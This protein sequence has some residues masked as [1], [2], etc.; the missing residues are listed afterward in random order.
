MSDSQNTAE[1]VEFDNKNTPRMT[2][3][4]PA[5]APAVQLLLPP[6]GM[7]KMVHKELNPDTISAATTASALLALNKMPTQHV[8][9]LPESQHFVLPQTPLQQEYQPAT[10]LSSQDYDQQILI[11]QTHHETHVAQQCFPC[12]KHCLMY[13]DG[14]TMITN[15]Q[16]GTKKKLNQDRSL[17]PGIRHGRWLKEEHEVFLVGLHQ[18]GKQWTKI[19]RI[20]R[21]RT[22]LQIRTHA[23]KYFKKLRKEMDLEKN[24]GDESKSVSAAQELAKILSIAA[25]NKGISARERELSEKAMNSSK[26]KS[27]DIFQD[28]KE[29]DI[30][31]NG[32]EEEERLLPEEM[33]GKRE[34]D[35]ASEQG[36]INKYDFVAE[37]MK[38]RIKVDLPKLDNSGNSGN[39]MDVLRN[40]SNSNS[41]L[42]T[43]TYPE[44]N[45]SEATQNGP[46]E[47]S[48]DIKKITADHDTFKEA[49]EKILSQLQQNVEN[50]ISMNNLKMGPNLKAELFARAQA[51][52]KEAYELA[53]A[54]KELDIIARNTH[55][56]SN[57]IENMQMGGA[58]DNKKELTLD[59][60]LPAQQAVQGLLHNV[61]GE[62]V[63]GAGVVISTAN[64]PTI[65]YPPTST[66]AAQASAFQTGI[67]NRFER[68]ASPTSAQLPVFS[69]TGAPPPDVSAPALAAG[70]PSA[71]ASA[72]PASATIA[73]SAAPAAPVF[74]TGAPSV[75][76][77]A[78]VFMTGAPSATSQAPAA[79]APAP[80]FGTITSPALASVPALATDA[81]KT[82][83]SAPEQTKNAPSAEAS[84][85]VLTTNAP[86]VPSGNI[87]QVVYVQAPQPQY[88]YIPDQNGQ[89]HQIQ[90]QPCAPTNLGTAS[91]NQ[92]IYTTNPAPAPSNLTYV[93]NEQG[94]L[95]Q[96]VSTDR[97]P[98]ISFQAP[99]QLQ[100]T[101]QYIHGT[102]N[103]M[104]IRRPTEMEIPVQTQQVSLPLSILQPQSHSRLTRS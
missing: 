57:T 12:Q 2:S 68:K 70:A 58:F 18:Y 26:K 94:Q 98:N 91:Q 101:P 47:T 32:W 78:P 24:G 60:L 3:R 44:I 79:V 74:V 37:F 72:A 64:G 55:G 89:L 71:L 29:N 43:V 53:R 65:A 77:Q 28:A 11:D 75:R 56:D 100:T 45:S 67:R 93:I 15:K 86:Q 59:Q 27:T 90:I 30:S 85:P 50:V 81:L 92:T 48:E 20:C 52:A 34:R 5:V 87:I 61:A 21:T 51:K 76:A 14:R 23:Q 1:V 41:G 46:T 39:L 6:P 97:H 38:K 62:N 19:S 22:V 80:A 54:C 35:P 103:T 102:A 33:I 63:D 8:S 16:K 82:E 84:S 99:P 7:R 73:R 88:A 83:D 17:G 31:V 69:R 9:A 95:M 40:S 104:E 49:R 42:V 66:P 25:D 96:Q 10:A 36:E 4:P 13:V